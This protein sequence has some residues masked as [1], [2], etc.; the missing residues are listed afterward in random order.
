[1]RTIAATFQNR[2]EAE[3]ESRRLQAIGVD[4]D[5]IVLKDVEDP[6][7]FSDVDGTSVFLSA[8][9]GPEQ[10]GAASEI[11]KRPHNGDGLTRLQEPVPDSPSHAVSPDV[12]P[13]PSAV[14]QPARAGGLSPA[15]SGSKPGRYVLFVGS[16]IAIFLIGW[17]IGSRA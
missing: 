17:L 3:E 12:A 2:H 11:L 4:A 7:G 16:L 1:M 8:K 10:I 9:V 6:Q 14:R 15:R 13:T 5:R